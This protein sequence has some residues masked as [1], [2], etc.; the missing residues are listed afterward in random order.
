MARGPPVTTKP[1]KEAGGFCD[2]WRPYYGMSIR[3]KCGTK[4]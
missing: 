4:L 3:K 1:D 2:D